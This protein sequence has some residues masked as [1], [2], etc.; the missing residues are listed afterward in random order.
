L[1]FIREGK[2]RALAVGSKHPVAQLPGVPP[3]AETIPDFE[4]VVWHGIV[5]PAGLP[6]D[7]TAAANRVFNAVIQQPEVRQVVEQTQA[8]EVVG[9][10]PEEFA[11]FIRGQTERWVPVIRAAGIKAD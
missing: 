10:T 7:I 3:L 8:G 9:G 1:P 6:P 2:L 5:A 4:A 11:A